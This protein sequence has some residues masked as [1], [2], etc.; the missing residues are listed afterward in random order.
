MTSHK[1]LQISLKV[2]GFEKFYNFYFDHFLIRALD[3]WENSIYS[4]V[5]EVFAISNE[6]PR[7]SSP[8]LPP[9]AHVLLHPLLLCRRQSAPLTA[10]PAPPRRHLLLPSPPRVIP[11]L[12]RHSSSPPWLSRARA[13][14]PRGSAVRHLAVLA[15]ACAR[16]LAPS[17]LVQE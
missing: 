6:V 1:C 14:P 12:E 13:T 16:P 8:R 11:Q 3:Q 4:E 2:V 17:F 7:T 15:A 10:A 9:L 5:P